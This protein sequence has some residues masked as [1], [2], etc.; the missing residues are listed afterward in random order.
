MASNILF[1]L[2][3]AQ[4]YSWAASL[5][6]L[7]LLYKATQLY[8]KRR[9]LVAAF[10]PFPGPKCHWLYG[11]AH[12]FNTDGKD[13]DIIM[14]YAKK[15]PY[16]YPMWLGNFF[17]SLIICHPDYAKAILSR[18]DPKDDFGYY[19]LT[20]WIGKGLL[21]LSGQKWFQHRRLL[22]PAFHY[23][24]LKPYVKLMAD[25]S[26]VMLDKWDKEISDKKPVE[27]F[28][29]V[30]LMTLDS[31]MKCAF[32][33]HS[34]CQNNSEN[35]YIKAVYELSYLV[36]HRFT[37]LPYHSDFIFYLSP[38]GFRFRRAL[39]V[40]HDHTD[41]VI[42][43]RKKS[44]HEQNELE[45]IQQKRHLDFLDILL[46]AKDENGKGL[47]DEDLRAE[48][49]TFMFEGHDTTASG[50]SW[51]LYCMAKYPEHQQKCREEIRDVLGGKQTVDW[52]DL[53]KMPYTTLCIKESLR[54]YPPVP[55]IARQLTQ[56][57]TFC[58]GRSLP[59]D[60]MV[61]LSL[62]AINRC[63]SI[64]EDPEVFDPMRFSAENSAKRNSHA[65]LPFSAGSRNCIGQNFAMNEMKVALALTLQRFELFPDTGIEPLTAPQLVLRSLNGIHL[66]LKRVG[67]D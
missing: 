23:D 62:Y 58:D 29:H 44:L 15:Y 52:D 36:D 1:G 50:I 49:D 32:S 16:A 60:S 14:N 46:C 47:S 45:K 10:S 25:C 67:G 63:S 5:C 39:K 18:Q 26:N 33:Y 2:F 20:P 28:H 66:K 22:T 27:L 61:L 30:S 53:G 40:A 35:K 41:K 12:E 51:T 6:L 43:Q 65:F 4:L 9:F 57:I 64:W 56:P 31:I 42:K 59:K 19:F 7:L 21:V 11:N 55:G 17:A 8:L 34:N 54:L 13:M 24:V 38:H 37:F 48:V 3:P